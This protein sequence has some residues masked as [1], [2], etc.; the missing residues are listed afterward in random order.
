MVMQFIGAFIAASVLVITASI[1]WP[2]ITKKDRPELLE[3]V[4]EQ[5]IE[6]D[7]GRRAEEVLGGATVFDTLPGRVQTVAGSVSA[8]ATTFIGERT[9]EVVTRRIIEEV[10]K[11]YE[12]MSEDE[13][14]KMRELICT[15]SQ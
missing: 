14:N 7:A 5:V 2:N 15:P 9:E 3:K 13:K 8:A 12:T 4:H 11:R 1:I 10:T 6:T